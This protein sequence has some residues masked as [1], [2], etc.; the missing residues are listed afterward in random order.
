MVVLSFF[1]I[2]PFM[3]RVIFWAISG[4]YLDITV[5]VFFDT[6]IVENKY[7]KSPFLTGFL[8]PFF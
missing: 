2:S 4:F 8:D 3:V 5:M 6:Q 7:F 1:I